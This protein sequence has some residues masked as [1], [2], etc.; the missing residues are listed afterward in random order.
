[1]HRLGGAPLANLV[2]LHGGE[3]RGL[4][5]PDPEPVE[6]GGGHPAVLLVEELNPGV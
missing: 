5:G 1:M 4:C 2:C 3:G 6:A